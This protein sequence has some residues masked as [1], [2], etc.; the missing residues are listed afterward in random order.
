MASVSVIA[1]R[2]A[3]AYAPEHTFAAYDLALAMGAS[4]IELDVRLIAGELAVQHDRTRA[5]VARDPHALD[6]VLGR[7]GR[8]TRY[9]IELKDPAPAAERALVRAIAGHRLRD[10]VTLQAF[11]RASLRRLG[12]LDRAL[13][14]VA[15]QR[16]GASAASVRRRITLSARGTTGVGPSVDAVDAGVVDA[17]RARG[18]TVQP[19]TVN[20]PGEMER[21]VRLGVDGIFTDA[22]DLLVE[23]AAA[24]SPGRPGT[25]RSSG[26]RRPGRAGGSGSRS[27]GTAARSSRTP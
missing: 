26:C 16:E 12:R 22:P 27:A 9:W 25:S 17:A 5:R 4:A 15:L 8:A 6:E 3:S 21:L 1:H 18:L 13:P 14:R 7:Y 11:D 10:R 24:V 19:Y 20:D 23:V 2:G